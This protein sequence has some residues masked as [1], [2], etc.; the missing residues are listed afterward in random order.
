[1]T[2]QLE[3]VCSDGDDGAEVFEALTRLTKQWL[4]SYTVMK[5]RHF[6]SIRGVSD[7]FVRE[8]RYTCPEELVIFNA[9]AKSTRITDCQFPE[10]MAGNCFENAFVLALR[11]PTLRYMEGWA[12]MEQ[13]F[14]THHAWVEHPDGSIS[15]PT[16]LTI[17]NDSARRNPEGLAPGFSS[18]CVYMGVHVPLAAHVGWM[19]EK[20]TMNLL[21]FGEMT[22]PE[23]L[24]KGMDAFPGYT[25]PEPYLAKVVKQ[26]DEQLALHPKWHLSKTEV[27]VFERRDH[28]GNV[29]DRWSKQDGFL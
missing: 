16:W 19:V 22:D 3:I 18:R 1:M 12:T 14:P 10:M 17:V 7:R 2:L 27:G 8:L 29:T 23:V 13:S 21:S 9:T 4:W 11:D 25:I 5:R 20:N 26:I 15:D 28:Y 6:D 24:F